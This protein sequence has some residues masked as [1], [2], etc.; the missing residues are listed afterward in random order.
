MINKSKYF[1]ILAFPVIFVSSGSFAMDTG[2]DYY[3]VAA[4]CLREILD[5]YRPAANRTNFNCALKNSD[6]NTV[7][8]L[9]DN[10]DIVVDRSV[11][12]AVIIS[13]SRGHEAKNFKEKFL[14]SF[15]CE[16]VAFRRNLKNKLG[17][18]QQE[19]KYVDAPILFVNYSLKIK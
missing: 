11:I 17:D 13:G 16:T 18:G 1:L 3:P 7:R 12:D 19:G 6:I 10:G 8:S 15:S 2:N 4:P 9:I 5:L 14:Q